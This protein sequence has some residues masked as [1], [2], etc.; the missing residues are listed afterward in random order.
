M[1]TLVWEQGWLVSRAPGESGI[2]T[3][4]DPGPATVHRAPLLPT[5][6]RH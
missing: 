4:E 3:S 6:P 5:G 1:G 2:T